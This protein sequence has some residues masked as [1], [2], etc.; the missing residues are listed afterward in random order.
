MYRMGIG[1]LDL[2][3][4]IALY[5][6]TDAIYGCTKSWPRFRITEHAKL[7]GMNHTYSCSC[8]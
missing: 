5:G 4:N 3:R 6:C 8:S 7:C 2:N 1:L